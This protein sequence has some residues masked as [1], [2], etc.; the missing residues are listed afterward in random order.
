MILVSIWQNSR[1]QALPLTPKDGPREYRLV[2]R[3]ED[4]HPPRLV[5]GVGITG[6]SKG[7]SE[8]HLAKM[9]REVT[10]TSDSADKE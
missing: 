3:P 9:V 6:E 2:T 10:L 5:R 4:Y 7:T 1:A 8:S